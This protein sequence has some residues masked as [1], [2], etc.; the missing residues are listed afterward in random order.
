[1]KI[2][3][4]SFCIDFIETFSYNLDVNLSSM[5]DFLH[6]YYPHRVKHIKNN[7]LNFVDNSNNFD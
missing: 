1:M 4:N 7:L 5:V 3:Y 6:S 2:V